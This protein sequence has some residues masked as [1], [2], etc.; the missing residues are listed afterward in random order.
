MCLAVR[1]NWY[2]EEKKSIISSFFT[3]DV[4][5]GEPLHCSLMEHYVNITSSDNQC[6]IPGVMDVGLCGGGCGLDTDTCC[7]PAVTR[8]FNIN[9]NCV[10]G[11]QIT[12]KVCM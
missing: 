9:L 12:Q 1:L 3:G 10:N 4:G 5:A 11:T 2:F 6:S 7:E 8:E